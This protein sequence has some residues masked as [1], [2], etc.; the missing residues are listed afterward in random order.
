MKSEID[1][2]EASRWRL[3]LVREIA[4]IYTNNAKVQAV[5]VGGSVARGCA[6][7]YSDV[8]IGVFWSEHPSDA[9]FEAGMRQARGERWELDPYSDEDDVH[10]EEYEVSG[11]KIDLR[12]MTVA[13]MDRVVTAVVDQ[14]DTSEERQQIIWAMQHGIAL[15]G[16]E[17]VRE[18]QERVREYPPEL[19]QAMVEKH[20]TFDP[21]WPVEM[22][23]RRGDLLLVYEAFSDALRRIAGVLCGLNR[24]YSP[25]LKWLDRTIGEMPLCPPDLAVRIKQTFRG[26]PI[27]AAEQMRQLIEETLS[28][29]EEQLPEV[30]VRQARESFRYCR[31]ALDEM[32]ADWN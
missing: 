25:G 30:N 13:R 23:A 5:I 19:A 8:E 18:W 14:F 15:A 11:L 24:R 12:H 3:A 10:Y 32:P 20:M 31:P 27:S 17:R 9:E 29:V 21:W 22:Y 2:N 16:S 1:M 26:E 6:D 7:R 4:P 28:L